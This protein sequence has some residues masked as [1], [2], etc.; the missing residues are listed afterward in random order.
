MCA[1]AHR[2][3]RALGDAYT[4]TRPDTHR[5]KDTR[6]HA[7][8][9]GHGHRHRLIRLKTPTRALV[10]P[11]RRT[12]C[13]VAPLRCGA[14]LLRHSVARL[15]RLQEVSQRALLEEVL[16]EV[17]PLVVPQACP[18]LFPD[19]YSPG[20]LVVVLRPGLA[21]PS[22][23]CTRLHLSHRDVHWSPRSCQ[24]IFRGQS[25]IRSTLPDFT[26]YLSV[27]RHGQALESCLRE[28][29]DLFLVR[30]PETILKRLSRGTFRASC[31]SYQPWPYVPGGCHRYRET[32]FQ[33]EPQATASCAR[34]AGPMLWLLNLGAVWTLR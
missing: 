9:H 8:V 6:S 27:G 13:S 24:A 21:S 26:S 33:P 32:R 12:R 10:L 1:R 18:R 34:P 11:H 22:S 29:H 25:C 20:R 2:D 3:A 4:R 5:H 19:N 15:L 23:S 31:F 28:L 16:S 14:L 17:V 30:L 7:E